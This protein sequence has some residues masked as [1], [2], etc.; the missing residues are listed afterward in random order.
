MT[1]TF[2]FVNTKNFAER[3]H[4]ALREDDLKS[5]IMFSKMS[6]EERDATMEKFRK[7]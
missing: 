3:V 2:I 7:Q 6:K 1:Q 4:K 5:N